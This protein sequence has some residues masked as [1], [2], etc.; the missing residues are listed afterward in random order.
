MP[1]WFYALCCA[2]H[3]CTFAMLKEANMT[4]GFFRP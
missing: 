4:G 2:Y 3:K 1:W